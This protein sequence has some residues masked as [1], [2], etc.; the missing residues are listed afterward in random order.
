MNLKTDC[1][2]I[3]R[4]VFDNL[5]NNNVLVC[6]EKNWQLTSP[7]QTCSYSCSFYIEKN[8]KTGIRMFQIMIEKG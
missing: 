3:A 7:A 8:G 2:L 4:C 1:V 6:T 5:E